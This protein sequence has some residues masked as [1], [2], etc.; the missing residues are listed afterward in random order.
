MRTIF[1]RR[2]REFVL[3]VIHGPRN[4]RKSVKSVDKK[5][6]S[7]VFCSFSVVGEGAF[8]CNPDVSA[9]HGSYSC[10]S[11]KSV[12]SVIRKCSAIQTMC[13][14]A[15]Y[16]S[17][18]SS[19]ARKSPPHRATRNPECPGEMRPDAST[20][21]Q[22]IGKGSCGEN[23]MKKRVMHASCASCENR[24]LLRNADSELSVPP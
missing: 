17:Y 10:Y 12:L 21:V 7:S 19:H 14:Y 1:K 24:L 4:R 3:C 13:F 20:S 2:K 8:L 22:W 11:L 15:S 23:N 16:V 5:G 9:V 6:S 18:A